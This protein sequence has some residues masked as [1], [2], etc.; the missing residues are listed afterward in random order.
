M[1]PKQQQ[2]NRKGKKNRNKKTLQQRQSQLVTNN[3]RRRQKTAWLGQR[4]PWANTKKAAEDNSR[5]TQTQMAEQISDL[6]QIWTLSVGAN[7]KHGGTPLGGDGGDDYTNASTVAITQSG[8]ENPRTR[9]SLPRSVGTLGFWVENPRRNTNSPDRKKSTKEAL[10]R[11]NPRVSRRNQSRNERYS[12]N[13]RNRWQ[14]RGEER[15][16][17]SQSGSDTMNENANK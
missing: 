8:G 13:E 16:S 2:A 12:T 7:T 3:N 4:I 14:K 10:D 5:I 1:K 17:I 11:K 9:A 6:N 15:K